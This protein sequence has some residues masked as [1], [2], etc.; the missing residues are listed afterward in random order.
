MIRK[1]WKWVRGSRRRSIIAGGLVSTL[2][3][4]GAAT[5]YFLAQ[6]TGSGSGTQNF[7]TVTTNLTLHVAWPDGITPSPAATPNWQPLTLTVDNPGSVDG[8][9]NT[10]HYGG[11]SSTDS[12]CEAV[13]SDST[14]AGDVIEWPDGTAAIAFGAFSLPGHG[15]SAMYNLPTPLPVP[16]GTTGLTVATPLKIAFIDRGDQS[17]CSGKPL[18]I[19]F[20]TS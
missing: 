2:I 11:A 20:T 7:G 13:L 6:S 1:C 17:A 3:V 19:A 16:A 15:S 5:A 18:T 8:V 14:R 4:A 9:I 10:I 12:G